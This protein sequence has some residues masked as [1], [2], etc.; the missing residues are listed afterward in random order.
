MPCAATRETIL[1]VEDN[2]AVRQVVSTILRQAGYVV[3]HARDGA[4]ALA[5]AEAIDLP[6]DLLLSDIV[7]PGL[8]VQDIA[9]GLRRLYPAI[10]VQLM[11]GYPFDEI[12]KLS[13]DFDEQAILA[14]PFSKAQLLDRVKHSL[15]P[16]GS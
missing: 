6:I 10:R 12:E 3:L 8:H 13:Q 11:T 2:P 9:D 4:D 15:N 14:K 1:V 7:L 5:V 16:A